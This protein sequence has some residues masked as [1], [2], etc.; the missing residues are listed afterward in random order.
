MVG[1]LWM[2]TRVEHRF[3]CRPDLDEDRCDSRSVSKRTRGLVQVKRPGFAVGKHNRETV[4]RRRREEALRAECSKGAEVRGGDGAARRRRVVDLHGLADRL[5][6]RAAIR[7]RQQLREDAVG[8]RRY[9]G[10]NV[11]QFVAKPDRVVTRSRDSC[12]GSGRT[13]GQHGARDVD[14]EERLRVRPDVDRGRRAK[15]RLGRCQS[16]QAGDRGHRDPRP[17]TLAAARR[18]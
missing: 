4:P 8:H 17:P 7:D 14:H 3:A 10:R 15:H 13:R 1:G 2:S 18:R 5:F 6:E 9:A 16:E 12:L 11:D